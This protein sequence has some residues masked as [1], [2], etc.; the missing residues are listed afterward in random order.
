MDRSDLFNNATFK[1]ISEDKKSATVVAEIDRKHFYFGTDS[2]GRDLMTRTLIAGRVS[3]I[4]GLLA[5]GVA[6]LIGVTY[7][8]LSGYFGGRSI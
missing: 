2:N 4:I 5:S 7:G 8:S 6:L 3:L 1:D